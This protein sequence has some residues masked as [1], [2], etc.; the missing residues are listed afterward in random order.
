[1][2]RKAREE[3]E[4]VF[5][6]LRV[7]IRDAIRGLEAQMDEI[8]SGTASEKEKAAEL[9]TAKEALAMAQESLNDVQGEA[10]YVA[11]SNEGECFYFA[12]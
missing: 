7:R 3:T 6:P 12:A 5:E 8:S 10:W 1:M 4:A 9:Q 11:V 2:Q